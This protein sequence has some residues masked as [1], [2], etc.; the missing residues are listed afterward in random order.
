MSVSWNSQKYRY[1]DNTVNYTTSLHCR[2]GRKPKIRHANQDIIA[3]DTTGSLEDEE[4][5]GKKQ[6]EVVV[7]IKAWFLA[8]SKCD[9]SNDSTN[10]IPKTDY[11][12]CTVTLNERGT[13]VNVS[14]V[15]CLEMKMS[16]KRHPKFF[17]KNCTTEICRTC[18]TAG[19]L[20]HDVL[21]E[22]NRQFHCD[23]PHHAC[24]KDSL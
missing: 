1:K 12:V 8:V 13:R 3:W 4:E 14:E 23:S 7:E 20:S 10:V 21:W 5:I 22:G 17:C 19:C 16:S 11:K 6:V 9:H 15:E 24:L 2:K 18:F